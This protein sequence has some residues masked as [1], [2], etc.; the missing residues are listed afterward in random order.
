VHHDISFHSSTVDPE[1]L[2]AIVADEL[3]R[4]HAR[5]FWRLLVKR[6]SGLVL[7]GAIAAAVWRWVL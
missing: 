5:I 2:N 4:A 1:Q 6:L 3:A 7:L